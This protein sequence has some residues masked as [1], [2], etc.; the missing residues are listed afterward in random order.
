MKKKLL[1]FVILLI[2]VVTMQAQSF[3]DGASN[4][5]SSPCS[6]ITQF[7]WTEGFE[8]AFPAAVA[9]GNA[10][11]P[12]CWINFNEGSATYLWRRATT[13]AYIRTGVGSA[14]HY[15]SSSTAT[16][17]H[18][19][20]PVVTL[21]GNERLRFYVKGNSTYID[22]I[23][24]GIFSLTQV[25]RDVIAMTDTAL[26]TNILP[27]TFAPQHEWTEIIINLNNY[28]GDVRIAFIR[29]S[30]GG[31]YLNLDDVTIETIPTCPQPIST[32]LTVEE[33]SGTINWIPA[34]V[35]QTSFL[36]FYKETT[37]ANYDSIV[38]NANTYTLQNLTSGTSYNFYVKAD[39]GIEFSSSTPVKTFK[40]LC[41]I[42]TSL[43][44]SESFDTYTNGVGTLP[45]CWYRNSTHIDYP[46]L[47][48]T[49]SSPPSSMY[50]YSNYP[51]AYNIAISP[52]ID[53]SIQIN[54]LKA[55][56]KVRASGLDDTL[57]VGVMTNP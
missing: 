32:S 5:V 9:P 1:F 51:G 39:C 49:N 57:F 18:L 16:N 45:T 10:A 56:L 46:Y 25:G 35:S 28:V 47:N 30:L 13:A 42:I 21:T 12:T 11:A 31:F 50:F 7:P 52:K 22:F 19:I 20:T 55:T 6:S 23:K 33:T 14:Q 37:A 54:N 53:A 34:N 44:V 38:V 3:S 29:N 36:L 15:S 27:N 2:T 40:T 41:S 26:F 8:V 48:T 4:S 24:V 17:D 43:P